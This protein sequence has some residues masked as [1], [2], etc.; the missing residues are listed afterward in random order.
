MQRH[1]IEVAVPAGPGFVS[2]LRK[3]AATAC[4]P[5]LA[6]RAEDIRLARTPVPGLKEARAALAVVEKIYAKSGYG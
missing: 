6:S 3:A 4:P 1:A 2:L 5:A